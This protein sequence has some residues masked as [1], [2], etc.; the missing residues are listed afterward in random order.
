M[1]LNGHRPI[2]WAFWGK[3]D[4]KKALKKGFCPFSPKSVFFTV[5]HTFLKKGENRAKNT[6]LK[7][8][9]SGRENPPGAPTIVNIASSGP[10]A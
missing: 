10:I 1:Q 4:L 5:F 6:L 3:N 9:C 2:F 8:A 7:T